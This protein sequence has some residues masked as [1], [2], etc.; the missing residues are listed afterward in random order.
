MHE[1]AVTKRGS[2]KS[3]RLSLFVLA[4]P[5]RWVVPVPPINPLIT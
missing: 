3:T 5:E 1:F 2:L 4:N